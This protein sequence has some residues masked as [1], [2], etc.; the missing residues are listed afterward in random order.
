MRL[1]LLAGAAVATVF[2]AS[3]ALAQDTGWYG[4][5]DV[6][7]HHQR[8]LESAFV[9]PNLPFLVGDGLNFRVR[10]I[11]YAGFVRL[12]YRITPNFRLELEGG[13]RH[14]SLQSVT[15]FNG[16]HLDFDL[17][18][19]GSTE[20][21]CVG[22][23]QGTVNAWTGMLN[24]LIDILPAAR[25]DPF[26]GGGVGANHVKVRADGAFVGT[27]LEGT[28]HGNVDDSSTKF[29][30]QGIAGVAFRASERLNVDLTYRYLSGQRVNFLVVDQTDQKSAVVSGR[31]RDQSLTLGLRYSFAAPPPPPPAPPYETRDYVIYFPFDQY[32]IT[33]EAQSVLQDAAKYATDGHATREA[34][35]GYTDTSGSVAYNLRLSER[36]AKATADGLVSLGVPQTSLDVSWKGKSDLAVQTGDQVKEPLNRRATIHIQF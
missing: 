25:L 8:G 29:A 9:S 32:V 30:Y 19:M 2:A 11:D 14:G 5:I 27:A 33:P 15:D 34:V 1:K 13:Y 28:L 26:I 16:P 12:G 23:P 22:K 18:G 10:D 35:V 17:C 4:A 24:G 6:G 21:N 36:R 3:G 20:D 31:Y 7:G